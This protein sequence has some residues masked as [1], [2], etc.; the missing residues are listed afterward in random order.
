VELIFAPGF[1]TAEEVSDV[2]GRGVGM[3][4]V[5]DNIKDLNG[6]VSIDSEMGKGTKITVTLPLTLAIIEALLV[7]VRGDTYAIPLDAVSETTKI[8][9]ENVS[10]VNKR[11]ATTLRGE[12][13]GVAELAEILGRPPLDEKRDILPLVVIS[14][15]NRRLGLVVDELL[16]RQEIVIKSMGEYLGSIQGLSGATIM[17]DGS[18]ILILDPSEIMR[19]MT[20]KA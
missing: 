15:N 12:V 10:E 5:K 4:V 6:S 11:E 18:V 19:Q 2:S 14:V 16:Q 8:S 13:L 17:G 3:D 1:S 9:S 20:N 7:K